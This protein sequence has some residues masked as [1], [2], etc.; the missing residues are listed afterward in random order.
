LILIT[1]VR[2]KPDKTGVVTQGVKHSMNP[3]DEIAVEEVGCHYTL[4]LS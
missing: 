3:F 2:V 4:R 1:Q